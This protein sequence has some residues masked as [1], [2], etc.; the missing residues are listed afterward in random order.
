M[1]PIIPCFDRIVF[2]LPKFLGSFPLHGF[3][4]LVASGFLLGAQIGT[5]KCKR[6]GLDP[7]MVNR[8]LFWIVVGVFVGGHLG[9]AFLYHWDEYAADPIK[10]L[11]PWSGLSS[12]GG[13]FAC[14]IF[15]A[16][17][18]W[19]TRVPFWPFADV[20]AYGLAIGWFM[21]RMGC[22][23]AHDHPGSASDFWLAIPWPEYT[24]VATGMKFL[25]C[26]AARHD[27]G[28]YEALYTL[29]VVLAFVWLDRKPRF[30]GFFM[31]WLVTTYAP[32]RFAMDFLRTD[33][34][35]YDFLWRFGLRHL[36]LDYFGLTPGQYGSLILLPLGLM[37]LV[38]RW[39]KPPFRQIS[40]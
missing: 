35:K 4:I 25:G 14:A 9:D 15:V 16:I 11:Q 18:L 6:D 29:L 5:R 10:F 32:V 24:R 21:G 28:F 3:G 13:F 23:A 39:K 1:H 19:R 7:E 40:G 12:F 17:F 2:H 38:P 27:L 22:T 8:L 31:G 26:D 36:G 34:I 20:V 33:D 37:I 30:P